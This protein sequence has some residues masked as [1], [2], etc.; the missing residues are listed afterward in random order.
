M[1]KIQSCKTL[2]EVDNL[3]AEAVLSDEERCELFEKRMEIFHRIRNWRRENEE[4]GLEPTISDTWTPE[5]REA[6]LC[7]W[8]NDEIVNRGE[9][10]SFDEMNDDEATSQTGRGE[11]RPHEEVS[12]EDV[13]DSN[14]EEDE[15]SFMIESVK[16]VNIK[17]FKTKGTNYTVRFNNALA[18]AEINNLH[19]RLHGIFQ[20][21]LNETIGGVPPHDQVRLFLHSQQLD[22]PI[23]FPFMAPK[24]L[25]TERILS[26]FQR[27]IQSNQQFRLNETVDVNV[28]HVS[29]PS[30]GKGKKRSDV[31]LE[32]HLEKKKS[33]VRIQNK[34][35]LCMGRALVVAKAKIDNDS[36]DRQIRDHRRPLQTQLGSGTSPECRRASRSVQYRTCQK[37]SSLSLQINIVSKE[38]G[39]KII[40][41][42]PEKEKKIYL[43]MHNNHYDV[44]TK[45]PGFCATAY[46]CHDCKKAYNNRDHHRCPDSCKCCRFPSS[47]IEVS[48]MSCRDCH[49]MF[50]SQQCFDQHK[51]PRGEACSVCDSLIKCGKCEKTVD[52]CKQSPE[53]HQCGL[54]K[55]WICGKFVELEGHRCFIQPESKRKNK[56]L[57]EEVSENDIMGF[58]DTEC[59]QD[60]DSDEP[61]EDSMKELLF[62]DFECRQ[63]NGTHEPNLCIVQN[64]AG[65]EW[66][67][68]GDTT[69]K[70]FCEWLFTDEH[71]GCT[72]MA[73]NF[74]GYDSYFIL[75]YLRDQGVKYDV[76]MRG[77]KTLS[78]TVD[79][80]NIRFID[81]LNFIPMKLA[82]FPKTFG[83]EELTKGYF[84]HLFNK[85]E[86]ENYI[87][88][89]P[90]TP[91]YSPNGM[92][93]KDRETFLEWH[94]GMRDRNY[95]FNTHFVFNTHATAAR[96]VLGLTYWTG[97]VKKRT[98]LMNSKDVSGM[99]S[100]YFCIFYLLLYTKY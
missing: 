10:R 13:D 32:K 48:W 56:T 58:F 7:D 67:F 85:K 16:D 87:G 81:S 42:G 39:N 3:A 88:P 5:Q 57:S 47:C 82:N 71:A 36:R 33:I 23:N 34:G 21:I 95:V 89:I 27:V 65:D 45:M 43:Y 100:L 61:I 49:R 69:Q 15:R 1:E 54:K 35:D 93:P 12:D 41:N 8:K 20:Q 22:Y 97:T 30:S 73:H 52:R 76:I 99:V 38:Y 4:L 98:R 84:P 74:Q 68:Q 40:Y 78:L 25:T 75:Q 6:F 26:E 29:L 11:K 91:Y 62:F 37:I 24:K 72:V 64:E 9:K 59:R 60:D 83:I 90:P 55:C 28:I 94:Q 96:N 31:N 70:D 66:I 80:F 46:Y 86:N 50:K 63:E 14:D 17:K 44:I 77:G 2:L 19:E 79:M 51:Q 92:N 18:D 53:K